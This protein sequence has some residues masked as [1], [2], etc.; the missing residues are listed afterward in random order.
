MKDG[1][2]DN[3][4]DEKISEQFYRIL[5][6][7]L[8]DGLFRL[9]KN[10]HV[11]ICNDRT[12]E[13]FGYSKE[14][15][16]GSRFDMFVHPDNREETL[17]AFSEVIERGHSLYIGTE[18]VGVRKDGTTFHFH[19]N[20]T[21]LHENGEVSGLQTTI[22]DITERIKVQ[23]ALRRNEEQ[24]RELITNV[25]EGIGITN[26]NETL[27]FVNSAF[28]DMLGYSV[29]ELTEM[30][31][32]NLIPVEE[33]DRI[34]AVTKE[35]VE[36]KSGAYE[37][38][39]ILKSG[40]Q[41]TFRVSAVPRRD[42]S[43]EVTGTIAVVTDVTREKEALEALRTSEQRFRDMIS[44][45]PE[46]I[47]VTD[48]EE[49]L[50][51]VNEG[52]GKI[53][54]YEI[55]ELVGK[56]VLDLIPEDEEY[57]IREGTTRRG[58]RVSSSYAVTLIRRDGQKRIGRVSA[59]PWVDKTDTV[60]GTLAVVVDITEQIDLH[61][62][63]KESEERHRLLT[64][65][66]QDVILTMDMD[67]N[68]TY[69]SPS[70][71]DLLGFEVDEVLIKNVADV[72]TPDSL[73]LVNKSLEE[74]LILEQTVGKD[75]YRDPPLEL[76]AYHKD[77][78]TVWV[79]FSR[80][81]LHDKNDR[82]NGI[83][84]VGRDIT[85]RKIAEN[86]LKA[87]LRELELYASLLRHDFGNDLQIATAALENIQ[88]IVHDVSE[89]KEYYSMIQASVE[90]M[91]SLVSIADIK[92]VV[93]IE[94]LVDL[95]EQRAA[96]A[97]DAHSG[98]KVKVSAD[99]STRALSLSSGRLLPAFFDNMFRNSAKH[100]GRTMVVIDLRQVDGSTRI[101]IVDNGPG[102]PS[103]IHGRIFQR[104]AS[105]RGEGM[106][107]YLCKRIIEGY[108][109]TLELL[110]SSPLGKGAAFRAL[111]PIKELSDLK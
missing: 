26:L 74:T 22:R 37:L 59:A 110:E 7:N 42:D 44:S 101:D 85:R 106:G 65:H 76:E 25:A 45:V 3:S 27:I 64:E 96:Q 8:P 54:G 88:S 46:G 12:L 107:L 80:V 75:G 32:L 73:E 93:P 90:R 102:I 28:A 39:M 111:L 36:G 5:Y 10:G 69:V 109:G 60:I 53:V 62:R 6:E 52:F 23:E 14:E 86:R 55:E 43:G 99:D 61:F 79:E 78:S 33:Q 20:S 68:L 98:L 77:G 81:I 19:S 17:R 50:M 30:N 35:R 2:S 18:S 15:V 40:E 94:K 67:L 104:G 1:S 13:M 108:G 66:A 29:D 24:Y 72:L 70:V 103:E 38:R 31:I 41:R 95:V 4:K 92:H 100:A 63:L 57:K 91:I 58:Q 49:N 34:L 9:D 105:T 87:S 21:V 71:V 56:S 97:E 82:P 84:S 47:A 11:T 89:V 83:L 16:I 51:F 48:L